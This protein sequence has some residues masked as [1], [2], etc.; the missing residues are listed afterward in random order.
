MIHREK[1]DTVFN[2]LS[3]FDGVNLATR[4]NCQGLFSVG[5][6]DKICPP[7]TVYAAYNYFSGPK[8]IRVWRYNQHEGGATYQTME[9][10]RFLN[11]FWM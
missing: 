5:L 9:K 6:M 10:L 8:E 3:Y 11:S 1:I 7:S 4:A 2:T